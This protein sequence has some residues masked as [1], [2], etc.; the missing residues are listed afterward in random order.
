MR[1][2]IPSFL[3]STHE[4]MTLISPL[5]SGHMRHERFSIA[6]HGIMCYDG[7]MCVMTVKGTL[8]DEFLPTR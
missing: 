5:R 3:N 2:H 6:M 1:A 4:R 8:Q 7:Q